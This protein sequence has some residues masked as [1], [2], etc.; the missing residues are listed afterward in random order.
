MGVI[1]LLQFGGNLVIHLRYLPG[2]VIYLLSIFS[3]AIFARR[4]IDAVRAR[5]TYSRGGYVQAYTARGRILAGMVF[6]IL[7]TSVLFVVM[8]YDGGGGSANPTGWVRCVPALAGLGLGAVEIYLSMR[9]GLRRSLVVGIFP[10]ILGVVVSIEFPC[11]SALTI[12]IAGFGCAN[13]CSGGLALLSYL[14]ILPRAASD[15]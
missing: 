2:I 3:L 14:R 4:I 7:G 9:Y 10:M 13:L 6:A 8:R 5:I 1:I 11:V 15:T 12:L